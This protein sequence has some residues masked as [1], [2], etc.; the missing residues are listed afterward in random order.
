MSYTTMDG[1]P[2]LWHARLQRAFGIAF[3]LGTQVGFL[4]TVWFLYF[5]LQDGVLAR[6]RD[7]ILVDTLLALQFAIIHSVI[8]HPRV[9]R[10]LT[11]YIPS[12]FYGCFFCVVTCLCLAAVFA[13]WRG[14]EYALW[15]LSGVPANAMRA[16]F[17][18]S[19]VALFYSLHLS[20]LGYQTG[21][22]PW[23]HWFRRQPQPRRTFEPRGAYLW[24]R[25][26]IY[27]SFLGLIWFTP[28]MGWDHVLLTGIW[29]AYIFVG[30][31]L[32]DE[33]QAFYIGAAYR[34]YQEQVAG[35]PFVFFGPLGRR[36][37]VATGGVATVT[38]ADA[39]VTTAVPPAFKRAS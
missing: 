7:W 34:R 35:Y 16:A 11:R 30:S 21:L 19:W 4:I 38:A 5:F 31:Y 24:L 6:G 33:R 17:L 26:P 9:K 20:G 10:S 1:T 2:T 32:K 37:S 15:D 13:G 29:T 23:W 36:K 25:H 8:L 27:L 18:G 12:A 22:T 39:S 3:G 28:R 14:S